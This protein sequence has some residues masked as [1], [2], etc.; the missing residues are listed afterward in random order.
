MKGSNEEKKYDCELNEYEAY[1]DTMEGCE[2]FR[3]E[4][5]LLKESVNI[6]DKF[7]TLAAIVFLKENEMIFTPK[8]APESRNMCELLEE[9]NQHYEMLD[10]AKPVLICIRKI[11]DSAF[12][13]EDVFNKYYHFCG[14]VSAR[15][16]IKTAITT[17]TK[18]EVEAAYKLGYIHGGYTEVFGN[19]FPTEKG[20]KAS[21]E[22]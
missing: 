19:Y 21:K 3:K 14:G 15:S 4:F 20:V 6:S 22:V 16:F 18:E 10:L 1:L 11:N 9:I 7:I 13:P 12:V 8:T 2:S 5:F 17:V